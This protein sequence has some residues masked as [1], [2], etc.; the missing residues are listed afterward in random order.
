MLVGLV[1]WTATFW[2]VDGIGLLGLMAALLLAELVPGVV[3]VQL[4]MRAR[5]ER[6]SPRPPAGRP[7][8]APTDA[9]GVAEW[10]EGLADPTSSE[11]LMWR[12]KPAFGARCAGTTSESGALTCPG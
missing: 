11:L 3:A 8:P 9:A 7:H 12:S 4:A 6:T 5:P 2:F 10:S 1:V